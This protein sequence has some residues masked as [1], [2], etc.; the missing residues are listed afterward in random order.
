MQQ[1]LYYG[2]KIITMENTVYAQAVLVENG[3][4]KAVGKFDDISAMADKS[5]NII[6]LNGKTLMP[7]FTDAHSHFMA[8]ANST[9]QAQLGECINWQEIIDK[10]KEF[11]EKNNIQKG[12]WI[13]GTGYDQN[14]LEEGKAPNRF[15]LDK[16]FPDNPVFIQHASGH[17]G[18][19]NTRALEWL[20]ITNDTPCPEGGIMEKDED[21]NLTGYM[22]ENGFIVPLKKIPMPDIEDMMD[23]I[24]KAQE[25]YLAHGITTVQEGMFMDA[26]VPIYEVM[27]NRN[28]LKVDLVAFTDP[29]N[30][31]VI[32]EKFKNHINKYSNHFKIGGDKIFLDGSPQGRTAW[33]RTPY[34][35]DDENYVAYPVWDDEQVYKFV[36]DAYINDRQILAHCNGDRA[37]QQYISAIEKVKNETGKNS[38]RPVMVHAQL[39]GLDQVSKVKELG[40]VPS[41]FIA[42]IYHWGD[43]H[44]KNF[45]LERASTISPAGA[46]LKENIP[47]TFHQDSPV[48]EPDMLET[49]WCAVNRITKNN[50]KLGEKL[51]VSAYDALK[52]VT[53]NSAYQYFEEN[54]KGSI[55][56]GKVADFVIL[57]ENPLE[58]NS[59]D[60]K[61]IKVL[62]TIKEDKIVWSSI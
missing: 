13:R 23:A 52:A 36:Y 17:M 1:T 4:I 34:K 54:T 62:Q 43:V 21:G 49:V 14:N 16:I 46:A 35:G 12:C 51:A 6:N 32:K 15:I 38:K 7:A 50:V 33:M 40:I 25:N 29:Q 11:K 57:S 20:K 5:V 48:I 42:H 3:I 53:I 58:V 45:G 26:M 41:F 19:Y 31:N 55:R 28:L 56:E 60:I 37:A 61:N 8:C 9:L 24:V 47:F 22:E 30:S 18:V 59:M 39:L 2:G 10:L 27:L 44:I